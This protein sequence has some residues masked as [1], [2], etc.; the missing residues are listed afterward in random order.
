MLK[1]VQITYRKP[2]QNATPERT[3]KNKMTDLNPNISLITLNADGLNTPW[4]T[5]KLAD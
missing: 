1:I 3:N 4:E 5:Q 2:K